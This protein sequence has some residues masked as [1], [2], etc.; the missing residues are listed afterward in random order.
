MPKAFSFV[1]RVAVDQRLVGKGKYST[2]GP[3]RNHFGSSFMPE[4][5]GWQQSGLPQH[6]R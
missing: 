5:A 4:Q 6:T 3:P 2:D 1:P